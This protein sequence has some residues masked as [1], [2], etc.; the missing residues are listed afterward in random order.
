MSTLPLSD[1]VRND[2]LVNESNP[3]V[4]GN[5]AILVVPNDGVDNEFDNHRE[6]SS[7]YPKRKNVE[8]Q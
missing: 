5:G 1:L 7:C 4:K 3:R 2:D 8:R 6:S